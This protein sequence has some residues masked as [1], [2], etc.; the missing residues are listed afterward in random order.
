MCCTIHTSSLNLNTHRNSDTHY[1][2]V[3]VVGDDVRQGFGHNLGHRHA[4]EAVESPL[5]FFCRLDLVVLVMRLAVLHRL[6]RRPPSLLL[7]RRHDW[8]TRDVDM[9]EKTQIV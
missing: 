9:T 1:Q 4:V 3:Q 7:H 2:N 6:L 5:G 8:K